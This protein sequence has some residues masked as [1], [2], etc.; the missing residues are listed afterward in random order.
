MSEIEIVWRD[1]PPKASTSVWADR[2]APLKERPN[3]WAMV[4]TGTPKQMSGLRQRLGRVVA[5]KDA[6]EF[7]AHR[8]NDDEAELYVR[9]RPAA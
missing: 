7:R 1:P 5:L 4:K 9:Y 2:L 8:L 3:T 6:F